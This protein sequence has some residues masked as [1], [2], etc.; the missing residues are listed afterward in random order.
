EIKG[1]GQPDIKYPDS[2]SWSGISLPWMSMG[3]EIL[4]TPMQI[5]AL[6]NAVANGGKMMKPVFIEEIRSH[7]KVIKK[8]ESEVLNNHI[9]SRETLN[10]IKEMLEGVVD[11]GTASNLANSHYKIAGKTGTAQ[12]SLSKEGYSK[13]YQA[14]FVGYFPADQP[15][16]SCIVV[17]NAPSKQIYYGNVVAGPIFRDITDRIYVREYEM[18][19]DQT[20]LTEQNLQAPYSKS[21]SSDALAASFAH[22]NLTLQ[23]KGDDS[24]WVS[25]RSTPEGVISSSRLIS[26]QLVPNVVDMGLKDAVFLLESK[27]L[28]VESNGW[29]TVRGQSQLPGGIIRKGTVVRL[30]MSLKE[31]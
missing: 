31:G 24:P 18:H 10:H 7:G 5:L 27:G 28:K 9:C 8:G 4:L 6:Y 30:N 13:L 12:V 16:Y 11:S 25:T 15:K 29:G 2:D 3:Y 21:G 26:S 17:V 22:L 14:S 1:E 19:Q 20:L 23:Q